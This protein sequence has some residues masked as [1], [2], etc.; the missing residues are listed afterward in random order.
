[1]LLFNGLLS[2]KLLVKFYFDSSSSSPKNFEYVSCCKKKTKAPKVKRSTKSEDIST[3][4]NKYK[5]FDG[6]Q[7]TGMKVEGVIRGIMIKG[8]WKEK[9]SSLTCGKFLTQSPSIE[10][11]SGVSPTN[12]SHKI[13]QGYIPQLQKEPLPLQLEYNGKVYKGEAIFYWYWI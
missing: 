10:H 1:M 12:T 11:W 7:Y 8:E 4:Y 9:R 5:Q 13:L 2:K 3:S 6:K